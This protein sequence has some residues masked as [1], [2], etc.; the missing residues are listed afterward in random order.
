MKS[1][2]YDENSIKE[3]DCQFLIDYFRKHYIGENAHAPYLTL[4]LN[5]HRT[6]PWYHHFHIRVNSIRRSY[7]KRMEKYMGLKFAYDQ[8]MYYPNGYDMNM[9]LDEP[10]VTPW[11]SI[12]NL[13]DDFDGGYSVIENN[14]IPPKTGLSVIFEGAKL[15]HGVDKVAG[16]RYIYI[17]WWTKNGL[18]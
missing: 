18:S 10:V 13:N 9:H 15:L 7:I 4:A 1:I 16:N 3:R 12:C 6:L 8:I 2:Y 11:V 14:R 17:T 5:S